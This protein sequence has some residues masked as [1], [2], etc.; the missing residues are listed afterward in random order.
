MAFIQTIEKKTGKRYKVH[1]TEPL[2]GKRRSRVFS[3]AKDAQ[4]FKDNVP[5]ADYIH[6]LDTVSVAE[7]ADTWLKVCEKSGRKGREPVEK[8]TL[9]PYRLHVRY[10]K[11]M[12]GGRRLNEIS[13]SVCEQ[14]K[15][16]LLQRF[17]RPFAR[18]ILTSFKG[19]LSEARTQGWL[20]G[21]P[22]EN[23]RIILSE[24][25]KPKHE[26]W[27]TLADVR[28]ILKKADEKAASSNK[29]I[30]KRWQRYRAFVYVAVFSGMR[31]GEVLGLPWRNVLFKESAIKVEQDMDEDGTIG[32]P[33][34]KSAYRTIRMGKN[35]MALLKSWK[36]E[37]PPSAQGLV[38]P[39]WQGNPEKIQ[40]VYRRCW[41]TLQKETGLVDENG[42]AKYPLKDLRHV[43]ASMEIENAANPKEITMLMGHSSVKIT[44][45]VYGHLFEDHAERRAQRA[46]EVENQLLV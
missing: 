32:R 30:K 38:F 24:R 20:K 11:E 9:R 6:N 15:N 34:S 33:K 25:A 22:A 28:A 35:V 39:N 7:A 17:S 29:Q 19:I 42:E 36:K 13:P 12:V 10:I 8:S 27:L 43:R 14:F 40:N 3:R 45:D 4:H 26:S 44:Y 41:Y 37:C 21:D 31:P 16:D 1:Y 5:K 18:K 46:G 2:T 23:V